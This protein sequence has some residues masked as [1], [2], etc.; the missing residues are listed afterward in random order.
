MVLALALAALATVCVAPA[1]TEAAKKKVPCDF[2]LARPKA[3]HD[4]VKIKMT[5]H[6]KF[7]QNVRFKLRKKYT[8]TAFDG[9][10][11]AICSVQSAHVVGCVFSG[12]GAPNG[13]A[14]FAT[15][16]LKVLVPVHDSHFADVEIFLSGGDPIGEQ[17]GY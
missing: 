16:H 14:V 10:P 7:V 11:N 1:A 5:C 15:V 17:L 3:H 9:F 13:K 12:N 4:Q 8:A 2:K 6:R